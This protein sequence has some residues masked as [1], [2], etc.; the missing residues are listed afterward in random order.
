[1]AFLNQETNELHL[2]IVYSGSPGTGKTT[3]LQSLFKQTSGDIP[4]RFFDLHELSQETRFFDFLP[5]AYGELRAHSLRLHLYTLPPHDVWQSSLLS[6]LWGVDGIVHVIDSRLK[7]LTEN[8][9]QIQRTR[10]LLRLVNRS[11]SEIPLVF[12]FNHRDAADALSVD[13]LR[14]TFIRR[15]AGSTEAVA[16]Q[17]IGVMETLDSIANRVLSSMETTGFPQAGSTPP[18]N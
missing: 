3:N 6:L 8:E 1:M 12:Q 2:K 11:F 9:R 13:A 17:D 5:M 18:L 4:T 15:G 10:S 7:A 14:S 16:V